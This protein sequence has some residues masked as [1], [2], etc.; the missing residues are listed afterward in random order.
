M[1]KRLKHGLTLNL[2]EIKGQY[3]RV[4]QLKS[5]QVEKKYYLYFK[6]KEIAMDVETQVSALRQ[7]LDV[8]VV[9]RLELFS[10]EVL[11]GFFHSIVRM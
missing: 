8:F 2:L 4:A 11:H 7:Q 3:I 1:P 5:R 9:E 10:E 6:S